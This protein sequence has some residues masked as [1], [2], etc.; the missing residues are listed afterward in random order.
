MSD[1]CRV[2]A[3]ARFAELVSDIK[4]KYLVVSYNNTYTSKSHSSQN[5]ITHEEI[6]CILAKKGKTKVFEK[7]YRHF[8]S[9]KTD[10]INHK[11]Y[12]FVTHVKD[13]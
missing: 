12:I 7:S 9:G 5:K 1:Y 6:K 10:F 3:K 8:N 11:E 13:K 4:A 2:S